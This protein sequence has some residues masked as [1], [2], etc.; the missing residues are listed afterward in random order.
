MSAAATAAVL[1]VWAAATLV[2]GG[3]RETSRD[4]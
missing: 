4:A 3:W 2:V 1:V